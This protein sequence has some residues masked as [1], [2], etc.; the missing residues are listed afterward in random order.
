[1]R[2]VVASS[3]VGCFRGNRIALIYI[4]AKPVVVTRYIHNTR[5]HVLL[6]DGDGDGGERRIF[7]TITTRDGDV[8]LYAMFIGSTKSLRE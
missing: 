2:A 5:V 4:F 8:I 1:M 6:G 3:A 7:H